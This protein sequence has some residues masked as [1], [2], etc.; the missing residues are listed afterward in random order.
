MAVGQSM[1]TEGMSSLTLYMTSLII[2]D[3]PDPDAPMS[4]QHLPIS[5][6]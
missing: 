5:D 1:T 3:L 4:R 2:L 6:L